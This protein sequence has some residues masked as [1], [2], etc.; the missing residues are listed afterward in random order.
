MPSTQSESNQKRSWG[1]IFVILALIIILGAGSWM[2][3]VGVNW[4]ENNHLHPDERF[5]SMVQSSIAPV[6]SLSEYFDTENSSLNPENRGYTFFVYGTLP[7]FIV[8]LLGESL[9]QVDY[10]AITILGRQVSAV[11]DVFTILIIFFIG[12]RLYNKW[13]GLLAA[14]FYAFAVLPIQLSHFA[15]VDTITNTFATLAIYAAVWALSRPPAA[16]AKEQ[17]TP[18]AL[19]EDK[20]EIYAPTLNWALISHRLKELAPYILF[21]F[22]LGAATASK[23]NAAV[24]AM[25][26]PLV[27]FVRFLRLPESERQASLWPIFRNLLVAAVTSLL[28]FRVGQ[29]YA[30]EGPGFFNLAIN[31]NWWSSLQSLRAQAS[32]DVDFPPALQWARRPITF[33][34]ENLIKWG[35]GLPLGMVTLISILAMGYAILKKKNWRQHLPIWTFT[36]L[37]FLWQ[38]LSFVRTMRY[39]MLI[40]PTL[41]LIAGWGLVKLWSVR[42]DIK[43]AFLK[44][45]GNILRIFGVILTLIIVLSTAA[46]AFAFSNIYTQQHPRLA[47]SHWIFQNIPGALTLE[48]QTDEGLYQRPLSYQG[49][50]TLRPG[51]S[52][53][54]PFKAIEDGTISAITI[55]HI[56]DQVKTGT[57]KIVQL[58]VYSGPAAQDELLGIAMIESDFFPSR[59]PGFGI[60]CLSLQRAPNYST[61]STV[62]LTTGYPQR[63]RTCSSVAHQSDYQYRGYSAQTDLPRFQQSVHGSALFNERLSAQRWGNF[64]RLY[65][66]SS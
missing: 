12:R 48:M 61:G 16:E 6:E 37:Y 39:Q 34:G 24:V 3:L 11:F 63:G 41:T 55:P 8:R 18:S 36:V 15:T 9:G 25:V 4:D 62:L 50:D 59:K 20:D 10:N 33:S 47:A 22:A 66:L 14:A 38:S 5:L 1:K 30:F 7:I 40:Y 29:P 13:V 31:N 54:M 19:S 53:R 49:G 64:F 17:G 32:G 42:G 56:L 58:S 2:R 26:L 46:W 27:E 23:I 60:V 21:G 57:F 44:I 65:S 43:F 45:R 35:L 52:L 28:V 51:V